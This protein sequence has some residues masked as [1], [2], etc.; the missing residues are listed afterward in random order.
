MAD[1]P[2]S[3][4]WCWVIVGISALLGTALRWAYVDG[5]PPALRAHDLQGHLDYIAFVL[6]HGRMPS[7]AQGFQGYQPPLYYFIAAPLGAVAQGP[8]NTAPIQQLSWWISVSTLG[9]GLWVGWLL[10][11]T[12]LARLL[13]FSLTVAT[14]PGIVYGAS[15]ISNDGLVQLWLFLGF[16]MLIQ[17]WHT[18]RTRWWYLAAIATGLAI[19]TKSSG[20][21]LVPIGAGLLW[22]RR[23][24]QSFKLLAGAT[25]IIG[26][27]SGWLM[28]IR[29]WVDHTP[30]VVPN[31][32]YLPPELHLDTSLTDLVWFNPV[33]LLQYPFGNRLEWLQQ[34]QGL[35]EYYFRSAFFGEFPVNEALRTEGWLI[36]LLALTLLPVLALGLWRAIR[37]NSIELAPL[38]LTVCILV[39]VHGAYRV[40]APFTPSQDFRYTSLV[41]LPAVALALHGSAHLPRWLQWMI[42]ATMGTLCALSGHFILGLL[43]A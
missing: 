30:S 20:L 8:L 3:R 9:V 19:I 2:I 5:T 38:W 42:W 24:P 23:P 40:M 41:L 25:A 27:I 4:T 33:R 16:G 39:S 12:H 21:L 37:H 10:F 32:T 13:L 7:H 28:A 15:R 17:W 35:W 18:E 31:T 1:A 34:S 29:L 36:L 26:A 6:E 11:R 43:S 14:F 22:I